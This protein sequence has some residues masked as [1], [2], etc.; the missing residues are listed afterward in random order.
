MTF[1]NS[2]IRKL[3]SVVLTMCVFAETA[4]VHASDAVTT[5]VHDVELYENG[6]LATRVVDLQGQP[7]ANENVT[8][9]YKGKQIA[10][11]ASDADGYV[12]I[13][14]LRP[15]AHTLM[16]T[17]N[18]VSC[19]FWSKDTAPPAAIKVPALV[20]DAEIVRGQ[21]GAFN[22][23]MLVYAGVTAAALFV[24]IDASDEADSLKSRVAA[25]EAASP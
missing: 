16:T 5:R 12:V 24:A 25:L 9:V 23:P 3:T 2:S 17:T 15:G 13:S 1:R 18:A 10:T 6:V 14:G 19:R 11:G 4:M 20:S 22:L 21:F 8:V 7:V